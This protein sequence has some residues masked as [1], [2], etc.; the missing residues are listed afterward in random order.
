L[1]VAK[2]S[3]FDN[4]AVHHSSGYLATRNSSDFI[5]FKSMS[6]VIQTRTDLTAANGL[7]GYSV[8]GFSFGKA[9]ALLVS[10]MNWTI[11]PLSSCVQQT[12]MLFGLLTLCVKQ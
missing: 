5:D 2:S 10:K 8:S 4:T 3:T 12:L 1:K 11:H 6:A 9:A 7:T